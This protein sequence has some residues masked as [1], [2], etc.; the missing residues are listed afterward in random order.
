MSTFDELFN[1]L[2]DEKELTVGVAGKEAEA[3]RCSLVRKWSAQKK[4]YAALGFLS[5]E[6]K[7]LSVSMKPIVTDEFVGTLYQL[8]SRER[9]KQYEIL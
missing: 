2:V 8:K 9:R 5:V 4:M 1:K 3:L 7:N 6:A